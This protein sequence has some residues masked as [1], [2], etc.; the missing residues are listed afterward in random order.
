MHSRTRKST[1][2]ETIHPNSWM[3]KKQTAVSQISAESVIIS[4][5]AGLQLDGLPSLQFGE[6]VLET[7]SSKKGK[8]AVGTTQ[9]KES[10]RLT[11]ILTLAFLSQLTTY[12]RHIPDSS[13][14]TQLYYFEDHAAV[15]Q[16]TSKGRSANLRHV[17]RTHRVEFDWLFESVNL[18]HSILIKY[19]RTKGQLVDGHFDKS[20][21]SPRCSGIL[22]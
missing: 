8:G 15:F 7:L 20:A 6:Y 22:C 5:G 13:H 11:H 14:S 21:C 17:T 10:F 9:E 2:G 4:L 18:D 1:S 19:V 16:T 3:C 12:Q